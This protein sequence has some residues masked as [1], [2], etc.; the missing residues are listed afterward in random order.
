[1]KI[2]IHSHIVERH[3]I[4]SLKDL[5][6]LSEQRL[7]PGHTLLRK[8]GH[9]VAWYRD[10]MFNPEFRNRLDA[11]IQFNPLDPETIGHVVDKFLIEL[12]TQLDTKKV[13]MDIDAEAK[14]WLAEHGH[15]PKM[16]ARPMA[17]L[18][19][20]KIKKPLA[21]QLLFGDLQDGGQIFIT[22]R[23]GEIVVEYDEKELE[24]ANVT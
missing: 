2:D 23:D 5:L 7:A 21:E 19:Q 8:D 4:D 6:G 10:E 16:G 9:T 14:V 22:V 24:G 18:I 3:Y 17:R 15:D 20:D 1:M 13:T 12:E 11:I